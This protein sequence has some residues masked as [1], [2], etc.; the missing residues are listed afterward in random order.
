MNWEVKSTE[1]L[2]TRELLQA[3]KICSIIHPQLNRQT[4]YARA[5]SCPDLCLRFTAVRSRSNSRMA[6]VIIALLL[7]DCPIRLNPAVYYGVLDITIT[8][9]R[10]LIIFQPQHTKQ[11][12]GD[13]AVHPNM[14]TRPIRPIGHLIEQ[15][16]IIPVAKKTSIADHVSYR[17]LS[18]GLKA[19]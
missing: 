17:A 19:D 16:N 8:A 3:P 14:L 4:L 15:S 1:P 18:A 12:E 7:L 2:Y 9:S 6:S 11:V 5:N 10:L 13:G